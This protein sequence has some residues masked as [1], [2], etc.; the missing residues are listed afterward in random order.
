MQYRV[1]IVEDES[2]VAQ[3]LRYMLRR[4][5][6]EAQVTQIAA[7]GLQ[8]LAAA[9]EDKP[10]VVMT[11]ICMPDMDGLE[12]IQRLQE[13]GADC[14]YVILSGYSEFAY[15]RQAMHLGV[16]HYLTKPVDEAEMAEAVASVCRDV[17]AEREQRAMLAA[18]RA[19]CAPVPPQPAPEPEQPDEEQDTIQRIRQYIR[20]HYSEPITLKDISG[21]FYLNPSYISQLFRSKTGGTYISYLTEVRMKEACRLLAETDLKVIDVCERTGYGDCSYFTRVFEK[22]MG[23]RPNQY[24]MQRRMKGASPANS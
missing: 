14:G 7:N 20:E 9:R 15:A 4:S 5:L 12:M 13:E 18:L 22:E 8:G 6:P 17:T 16:R 23:C 24:R 1:L 2:V 19:Q 10:D 21:V 11:D 3:G